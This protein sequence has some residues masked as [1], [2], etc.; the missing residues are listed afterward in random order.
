MIF[1]QKEVIIKR[2]L[3]SLGIID[4]FD[5]SWNMAKN[6]GENHNIP[7]FLAIFQEI[8]KLATT[9][10]IKKFLLDDIMKIS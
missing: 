3:L 5:I 1:L 10:Q 9:S 6:G 7:V 8:L 4:H 2:K